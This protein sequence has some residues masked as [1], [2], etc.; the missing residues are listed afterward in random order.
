M[1][2]TRSKRAFITGVS[3]QDGSYLSE[4]LLEKGYEVHGMIRRA[5]YFNRKRIDHLSEGAQG[6]NGCFFLHYGDMSDSSNMNRLLEKINPHEIYNLAA[7]SHVAVSFEVPEYTADVDAVGTLRILDAIK[8]TGIKPKF[9]QAST[10]ELFGKVQQIPQ[11]EK[12]PFYPRSPYAVAKLYAYW[13]V[14]NYREA[15]NLHASNGI[16]FNHESPRRGENFV[17]RKITIGAAAI[18][19][20]KKDCLYLGNLNAKRD[21]GYAPDYVRAMWMML[22]KEQPDDFVIATGKTHSVREFTERAFSCLGISVRW[23]GNREK[24]IGI[25]AK[26]GKTIVRVNPKYY[27][28]TEV[29]LLIGN[30]LKAKKLL[31]WKPTVSF[32]QLV[33]IMVKA[34]WDEISR[35]E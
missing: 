17:T 3:G 28:P 12:T 18:K 23:S 32:D 26:T 20:G 11:S 14:I 1:K 22:Q 15:F 30:P 31:G 7:Q 34:D 19:A 21:W 13:I 9:Y 24:E 29:D 5:S 25:D 27:R 6:K 2:S 33:E 4:L 8:D 35:G 10:S 16:L